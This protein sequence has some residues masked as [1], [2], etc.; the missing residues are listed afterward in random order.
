MSEADKLDAAFDDEARER[1]RGQI[2]YI[3]RGVNLCVEKGMLDVVHTTNIMVSPRGMR[4]VGLL[5]FTED[6]LRGSFKQMVVKGYLNDALYYDMAF[7]GVL[8]RGET[9]H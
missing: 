8:S 9:L 3:A 1:Y 6:E 7:V 5:E 2:S 4:L